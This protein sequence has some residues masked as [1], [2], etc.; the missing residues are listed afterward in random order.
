M[1]NGVLPRGYAQYEIHSSRTEL[2]I[3]INQINLPAGTSLNVAVDGASVGS[4]SL[5]SGGEGRLRLRSDNGQ[6]VPV[7]IAGSTISISNGGNAIL[8]GTFAGF[9]GPTPS[10]TPTGTPGPT[11]SPSPSMGRSFEANLTGNGMTPPVTTG[12]T[13]EFKVNLNAAETQATVF[14]EFH[15]LSSA[16][17]GARIET[18]VGTTTTIR[19]FGTIGGT[20]GNFASVTFDV[21]AAQVQLLR[22]GLCSAVI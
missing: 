12:A 13:G 3:R 10:P 15:N 4:M 8:N 21:T 1:I 14:G 2:E 19:D 22:T 5:Q 11:P 6:T 17:T 9:G 18:L 7:V 20:N 16:Q